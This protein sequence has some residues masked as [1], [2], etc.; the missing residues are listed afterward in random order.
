MDQYNVRMKETKFLI[1][2]VPNYG[3]INAQVKIIQNEV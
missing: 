2:V 1:D 3:T